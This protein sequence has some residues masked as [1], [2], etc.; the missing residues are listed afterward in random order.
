MKYDGVACMAMF[1]AIA[2]DSWKKYNDWF[3]EHPE[4]PYCYWSKDEP[5]HPDDKDN[6]ELL[7]KHPEIEDI[8]DHTIVERKG[9]SLKFSKF[10]PRL[11]KSIGAVL[12]DKYVLEFKHDKFDVQIFRVKDGSCDNYDIYIKESLT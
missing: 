5:I 6:K 2:V 7:A 12:G 1:R 11:R 4:E 3:D 10:C 8:D 9:D